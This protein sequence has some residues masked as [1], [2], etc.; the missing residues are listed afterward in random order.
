ML[1]YKIIYYLYIY[2]YIYIIYYEYII[3]YKTTDINIF[4]PDDGRT[5]D[6]CS[7]IY[8]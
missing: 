8:I 4:L 6:T 5:T 7:N 2:I 1:Q 3:Y